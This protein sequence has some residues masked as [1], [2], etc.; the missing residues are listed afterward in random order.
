GCRRVS[1]RWSAAARSSNPELQTVRVGTV[2]RTLGQRQE[3]AVPR[4]RRIVAVRDRPHPP[5]GRC[6]DAVPAAAAL[7]ADWDLARGAVVS[8]PAGVGPRGR[9]AGSIGLRWVVHF[10]PTLGRGRALGAGA[11][12]WRAATARDR[13]RPADQAGLAAPR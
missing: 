6:Q 8:R 2:A 3:H 9:G 4:P 13:S 11:V 7:H 12:A 10:E 5:T 1:A